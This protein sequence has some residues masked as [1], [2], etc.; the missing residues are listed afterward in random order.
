MYKNQA[1]PGQELQFTSKSSHL[2]EENVEKAFHFSIA[3]LFVPVF[4]NRLGFLPVTIFRDYA[5][6]C[7]RKPKKDPG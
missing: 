4:R 1:D 3:A 5:E 6:I 2:N 7:K